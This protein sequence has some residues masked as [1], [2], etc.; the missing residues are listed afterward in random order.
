MF[1]PAP[2]WGDVFALGVP[3]EAS[4]GE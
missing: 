4:A 2:G 1:P 3:T